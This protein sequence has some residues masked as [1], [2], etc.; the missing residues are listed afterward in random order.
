MIDWLNKVIN[1]S[2]LGSSLIRVLNAEQVEY[3]KFVAANTEARDTGMGILRLFAAMIPIIT[4][5]ANMA[6]LIILA[7]GGRF[8]IAGSMTLGDFAAFN[9]YIA[10][11]IFPILVIGFMSNVIAQAGVVQAHR[12]VLTRRNAKDGHASSRIFAATSNSRTSR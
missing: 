7:L 11:L 8:V 9:S 6:T 5:V 4:F 1:E 3:D 2:I 12:Q 10:I